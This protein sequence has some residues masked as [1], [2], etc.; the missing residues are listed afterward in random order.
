MQIKQIEDAV[1]KVLDSGMGF[2][3]TL[4]ECRETMGIKRYRA[5]EFVGITKERLRNLELRFFRG[6]PR[7]EELR[8]LS[9]FYGIGYDELKQK[10]EECISTGYHYKKEE[11][12]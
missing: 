8:S 6:M 9:N 3:E 2:A 5:A 1:K 4:R 7:E 11:K 12:K 10:A